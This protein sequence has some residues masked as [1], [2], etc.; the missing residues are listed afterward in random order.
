MSEKERIIVL[1][2]GSRDYTDKNFMET[3]LYRILTP[4]L[5]EDCTIVLRNGLARGVDSICR[6][7]A[8]ESN[9]EIEDFEANWNKY[10]KKA[11]IIRNIQQTEGRTEDGRYLGPFDIYICFIKNHSTGSEHNFHYALEHFPNKLFFRFDFDKNDI[12]IGTKFSKEKYIENF[13][14]D[15]LIKKGII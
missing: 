8:I 10:G 1:V 6:Q 11:G 14:K 5:E 4:Y 7:I 2:S 15:F 13:E 3:W 12:C 9:W